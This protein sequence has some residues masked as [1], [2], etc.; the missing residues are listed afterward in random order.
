[1][2]K[3]RSHAGTAQRHDLE[4]LPTTKPSCVSYRPHLR[5]VHKVIR[6]HRAAAQIPEVC[7]TSQRGGAARWA[8]HTDKKVKSERK[9]LP[10]QE[11]WAWTKAV[12]TAG[13]FPVGQQNANVCVLQSSIHIYLSETHGLVLPAPRGLFVCTKLKSSLCQHRSCQTISSSDLRSLSCQCW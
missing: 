11:L 10:C 8:R 5:G 9:V 7:R 6:V 13:S 3:I 12:Y 4:I 1:M 2:L